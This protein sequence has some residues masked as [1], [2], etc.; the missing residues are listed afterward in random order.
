M[1]FDFFFSSF[2]LHVAKGG[3]VIRI[4]GCKIN[5]LRYGQEFFLDSFC[6]SF[7]TLLF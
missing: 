5:S 3:R 7:L 6:S 4:K 2:F 1:L